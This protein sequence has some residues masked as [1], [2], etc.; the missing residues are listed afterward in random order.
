MKNKPIIFFSLGVLLTAVVFTAYS[1]REF[2]KGEESVEVKKNRKLQYK[3]YVPDIPE[4]M[5]FAGEP[6]P[7]HKWEVAEGLEREVLIN[8]Y[9]HSSTMQI[10][11]LSSRYFPVIEE[12][13]KANGVPDDF[14][15]LCVAESSLTNATSPAG[16]KGFW[17]FMNSTAKRY[18][19]EVYSEV[20]ERYHL[21][22]ATDAACKYLKE[23]YSRFGSWTAAAASYN[24]GQAGFGNRAESQQQDSYYDLMLPGETMR[25]IYRILA[26]KYIMTSP[27]AVGFNILN[28]D[29]YQPVSTKS[30]TV[31][32]TIPDLAA[33][34]LYQ[35]TTYKMVKILNPWLRDDKLTIS[36]GNSYVIELPAQ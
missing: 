14:K 25:Y 21:E 9:R 16:A 4:Q 1:F 2:D 6:V 30:I 22:K 31:T 5:T 23:A 19:L 27:E 8:S 34:A 24:C 18:N 17:Q 33:F 10:L 28:Q 7:L 12:R 26:F 35:G 20:D 36:Q 32:Q 13:L 3:W 29:K 15:Y 11:R